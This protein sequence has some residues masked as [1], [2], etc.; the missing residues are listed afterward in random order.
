[1]QRTPH[2]RATRCTSSVAERRSPPPISRMPRAGAGAHAAATAAAATSP[3]CT[4]WR[5]PVG[6]PGADRKRQRRAKRTNAPTLRSRPDPQIMV[7]RRMVTGLAGPAPRS[8]DSASRSLAATSL[9]R[10]SGEDALATALIELHAA[11]RQRP[12]E[13][14]L[15]SAG[16]ARNAGAA[17]TTTSGSSDPSSAGASGNE[18]SSRCH[19]QG[20]VP[21]SGVRPH[22]TTRLKPASARSRSAAP[23]TAVPAPSTTAVPRATGRR[24]A[25]KGRPRGGR[26]R[27]AARKW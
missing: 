4:G 13:S 17:D 24:S 19:R 6:A 25:L 5:S 11:T 22:A 12:R 3:K 20:P 26:W 16:A 1:M 18:R 14:R 10:G 27:P 2:A 8:A 9:S 23:P 21:W 15:A 7:G